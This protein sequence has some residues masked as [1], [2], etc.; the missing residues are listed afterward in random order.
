LPQGVREDIA[1][2]KHPTITTADELLAARDELGSCD[3]ARGELVMQPVTE[4]V[5]LQR[6]EMAV[7]YIL[8]W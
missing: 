4:P 8:G 2:P 1:A 6:F 3:L 7:K 5:L